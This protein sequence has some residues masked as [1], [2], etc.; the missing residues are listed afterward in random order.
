MLP[1]LA[2]SAL[3]NETRSSLGAGGQ[4]VEMDEA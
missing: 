3:D 1:G 4:G 2:M